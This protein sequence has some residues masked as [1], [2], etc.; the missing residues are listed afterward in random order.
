MVRVAKQ[1]S[2]LG[3]AAAALFLAHAAPSHAAPRSQGPETRQCS[4][5]KY[6][7]PFPVDGGTCPLPINEES[8]SF[9]PWSH[10]PHCIEPAL[11]PL[12][13]S[14]YCVFTDATFR[15]GRGLSIITT[16]ELAA[17]LVPQL[18]DT[19]VV[20]LFGA[21][22]PAGPKNPKFQVKEIRGRGKGVIAK[23][24]IP[25]WQVAMVDIPVLITKADL[26]EVL[27]EGETAEL[28]ELA[29][30]QLPAHT[31]KAVMGLAH[32]LGQGLELIEDIIK[33]NLLPF[34]L[35]G[36]T[37]M[38][39]FLYNSV[40]ELQ[41]ASGVRRREKASEARGFSVIMRLL[42]RHFTES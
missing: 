25:K 24:R 28:K 29:V 5:S 17:A 31:R 34:D 10:R 22:P 41:L 20:D 39:L 32:S 35:A 18:D 3:W 15:N 27:D 40:S 4:W 13:S 11:A 14:E 8:D 23:K 42:T 9:A 33:T 7:R 2:S 30:S 16:P 1:A 36:V 38:G 6:G 21:H 19:S 37:H 26:F 12:G